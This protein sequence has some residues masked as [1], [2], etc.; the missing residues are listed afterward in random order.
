MLASGKNLHPA[1][2]STAKNAGNKKPAEAGLYQDHS[3][4]LSAAFP[5]MVDRP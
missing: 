5:A 3:N 4:S 2:L 1:G